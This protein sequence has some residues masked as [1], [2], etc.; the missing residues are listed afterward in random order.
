[1][2]TLAHGTQT[3]QR[4]VVP[5]IP[6]TSPLTIFAKNV[7]AA[8]FAKMSNIVG[9]LPVTAVHGIPKTQK[10]AE[11][12]MMMTS[13]PPPCAVLARVDLSTLLQLP[14]LKLNFQF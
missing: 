4:A 2:A 14:Q 11:C 9:I 13:V 5:S 1:M 7:E 6:L 12:T 8:E 3:I 10:A